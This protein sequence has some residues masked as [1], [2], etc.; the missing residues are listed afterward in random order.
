MW[1]GIGTGSE[2]TLCT[3]LPAMLKAAVPVGAHTTTDDGERVSLMYFR[4]H[5]IRNDFPVP[6]V[7]HSLQ[8]KKTL[9]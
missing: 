3:V 5:L 2:N 1:L 6:K 4:M 9:Q 8:Q 7:K